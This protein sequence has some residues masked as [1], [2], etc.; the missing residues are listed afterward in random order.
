VAIAVTFEEA[1]NELPEECR[2]LLISRDGGWRLGNVLAALYSPEQ[3]AHG[4][5][6]DWERC[7]QLLMSQQRFHEAITVFDALYLQMLEHEVK[8]GEHV[9]K[10]MPLVWISDCHRGLGRLVVA[11]RFVMLTLIED[12]VANG[13]KILPEEHGS[14]FRAAWVFGLS[15]DLITAYAQ[16][17]YDLFQQSPVSGAYP[18][19]I[20]Q[21]F[22]QEW[23]SGYPSH[24]EAEVYSVNRKYVTSLLKCLGDGS[25]ERLEHLCGYLMG[26]MPGCR[27]YRRKRSPSTDYDLVCSIDGPQT[28][29]RAEFGRYFV[30][31]C[32]D[33]EK[34]AGFSE[35]AKFC[36]VLDSVKAKF[37][38]LF[39]K[40]GISGKRAGRDATRE[41][42]KVF[43]DRG[44]IIVVIDELDLQDIAAGKSL[45][46][47]LRARYESVR[48]DLELQKRVD[49]GRRTSKTD[50]SP[51][52]T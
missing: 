43:Q 9:M 31:E 34:P 30:C 3:V 33:W 21:Q 14:Y 23:L 18:E 36:R 15:L 7:G 32:K 51:D 10:G 22:D 5:T 29:F 6:Q 28:D 37:G 44:I 17:S 2:A 38:I 8:T 50:Y 13:G 49:R 48:L 52:P 35:F 4:L 24:G 1:V 20:L 40:K 11:R 19:W 45:L 26:V 42:M 16:H 46:T 39:S 47:I 12:A 25:G 27:V 41:Q